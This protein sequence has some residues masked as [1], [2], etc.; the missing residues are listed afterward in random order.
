MSYGTAQS[1]SRAESPF[2]AL[3]ATQAASGP[4]TYWSEVLEHSRPGQAAGR[5]AGTSPM[6]AGVFAIGSLSEAPPR[7]LNNSAIVRSSP[8]PPSV[9]ALFEAREFGAL[10]S[11]GI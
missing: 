8:L 6:E 7:T 3:T 9:R 2:I 1:S 10:R 4:S 5:P 11:P